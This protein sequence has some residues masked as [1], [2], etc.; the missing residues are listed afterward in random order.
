MLLYNP[1]FLKLNL[2]VLKKII[3]V[4][5]AFLVFLSLSC[6]KDNSV[7]SAGS[8]TKAKLTSIPGGNTDYSPCS[9]IYNAYFEAIIKLYVHDEDAPFYTYTY[10]SSLISIANMEIDTV[11][12]LP[13]NKDT[14]YDVEIFFKWYNCLPTC[15]T[16]YMQSSNA[17]IVANFWIAF[18]DA[19]II[20]NSALIKPYGAS[21][22]TGAE[23]GEASF[24]YAPLVNN[25]HQLRG[26][27]S[28]RI[29]G[30]WTDQL[31]DV[32]GSK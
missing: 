22:G 28:Y 3:L 14:Q 31:A 7:E 9:E 32:E 11:G 5:F 1:P 13:G 6:Q 10:T 24:R 12:P 4:L 8:N 18:M 17:P 23:T 15:S 26:G 21:D 25:V 16:T 29:A 27:Q 30:W 19:G 2:I 20:F